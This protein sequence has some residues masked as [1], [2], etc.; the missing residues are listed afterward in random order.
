MAVTATPG[1]YQC[2]EIETIARGRGSERPIAAQAS[3]VAL[4]V[5]AFTGLPWPKKI[6]GIVVMAPCYPTCP[7]RIT[8][9]RA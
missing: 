9:Q 4:R 5:I 8:D 2:A 6:A 3:V 1:R 7:L